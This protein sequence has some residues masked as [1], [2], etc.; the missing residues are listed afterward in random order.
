[1]LL[2]RLGLPFEA[3]SPQIGECPRQGE[4]PVDL[5]L[6]LACDKAESVANSRPEAVVIGSD[7]VAMHEGRVIG[8]PG[9]A[10]RA[11][12]QLEA[13]SGQ[14]VQFLT[15]V[16]VIRGGDALIG[17]AVVETSVE[18]RRLEREEIRRYLRADEPFDCAGSFK[19]E[20]LGPALFESA[21]SRD[22]TALI[23]LPLIE[24]ARLL[25]MAG[26]QVP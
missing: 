14:I 3:V 9:S 25:R 18:F 8:K 16:A 15:S 26:F 17:E 24:T 23:G 10:E 21:F 11:A 6:R 1:M 20:S 7:Q 19:A 2:K 22:P 4:R 12:D 5:V 13:F